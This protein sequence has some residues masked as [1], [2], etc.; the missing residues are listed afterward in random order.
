MNKKAEY[1][2]L[3]TVLNVKDALSGYRMVVNASIVYPVD[4][5]ADWEQG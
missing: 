3:N 2:I 1:R 5:V 4:C